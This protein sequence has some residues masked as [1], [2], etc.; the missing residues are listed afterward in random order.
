M[1]GLGP[2]ADG[3]YKPTRGGKKKEINDERDEGVR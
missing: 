1:E 3:N 2:I